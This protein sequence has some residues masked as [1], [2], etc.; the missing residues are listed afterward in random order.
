MIADPVDCGRGCVE[1]RDERSAGSKDLP[2]RARDG[3]GRDGD[4]SKSAAYVTFVVRGAGER[5][6]DAA[7]TRRRRRHDARI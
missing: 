4:E 6:G 1:R 2:A 7:A 3:R 5:V